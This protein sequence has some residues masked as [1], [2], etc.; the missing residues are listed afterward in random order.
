MRVCVVAMIGLPSHGVRGEFMGTMIAQPLAQV[1][2]LCS[3]V[4]ASYKES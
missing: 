3:V 4:L 1:F 2:F